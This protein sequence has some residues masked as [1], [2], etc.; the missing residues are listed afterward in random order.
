MNA[1]SNPFNRANDL[2]RK[3]DYAHW[4]RQQSKQHIL[5]SQLGF[6]DV[7]SS[8]PKACQGCAHYHGIAYGHN[9]ATRTMLICGFHPSGWQQDD[10]CP[11]W[12]KVQ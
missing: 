7:T 4:H 5:R 8:R 1:A 11:D 6:R 9:R 10:R 3:A 2:I 12:D